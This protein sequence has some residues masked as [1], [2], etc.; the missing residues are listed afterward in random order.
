MFE[1]L[2]IGMVLAAINIVAIVASRKG[3]GA[4]HTSALI[5]GI[6]GLLALPLLLLVAPFAALAAFAGGLPDDL[7]T[8]MTIA[9]VAVPAG[10]LASA[11]LSIAIFMSGTIPRI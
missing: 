9:L 10:A 7:S 6:V 2:L 11:C 8:F 3:K 5:S 1:I 4:L